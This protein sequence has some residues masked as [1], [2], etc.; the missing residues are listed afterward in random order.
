M[1]LII[2]RA[3]DVILEGINHETNHGYHVGEEGYELSVDDLPLVLLPEPL[4]Q[5]AYELSL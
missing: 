1:I 4:K 2:I 5:C 3:I